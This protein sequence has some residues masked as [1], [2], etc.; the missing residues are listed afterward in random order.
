[1]N[2]VVMT[3]YGKVRGKFENGMY[4]FL[5]IPYAKTKRFLPPEEP[6]PWTGEF[7]ATKYGPVQP[8]KTRLLWEHMDQYEFAED[9][10]LNL[11]VW[12]PACDDQRRP[13]IIWIHGGGNVEGTCSVPCWDGPHLVGGH[14]AV[15]VSI[16]YRLGFLGNLY[17]A[18]LLGSEYRTSGSTMELDKIMALK[19]IHENIEKFGG[20]PKRVTIMG[21]SGGAK[22]VGNLMV[23]P[24]AKGLFQQA[25]MVSGCA[26]CLR[27]VTTAEIV[28]R[29]FL[30]LLGLKERDA[31]KLLTMPADE[32]VARQMEY[33]KAYPH[34][35]GPT[36]DGVVFTERPEEYIAGGGCDGLNVL[37]GYTRDEN[38]GHWAGPSIDPEKRR[39]IIRKR[40]GRNSA[41]VI[42]L[43]N[44]WLKDNAEGEAYQEVG[45]HFSY[46]TQSVNFACMLA[47]RGVKTYAYRWDYNGDHGPVHLSELSY[48]FRTSIEEDPIWGHG[49]K[50]DANSKLMNTTWMSFVKNGDPNNEMIPAWKP[51]TAPANGTR[52]YFRDKGPEAQPFD[53]NTY[54][55]DFDFIE[56]SL[57]IN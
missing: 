13:V 3:K 41:H 27:D 37:I 26:H 9:K 32:I 20:D 21:Q 28:T 40:F 1:M 24:L 49:H 31:E 10:G 45:A 7:D 8:Q 6:D 35:F 18:D 17:L 36:I 55:H 4:A 42:E 22:S 33:R 43:Y 5:G 25:I 34:M 12:T 44:G 30:D 38:G 19:W 11:N 23:S 53:L 15:Q 56:F 48:I 57:P 54:D 16:S 47:R 46:A 51:Y 14:N 50:F 29:Q 52:M 2:N 39:D